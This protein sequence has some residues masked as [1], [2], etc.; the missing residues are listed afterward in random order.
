MSGSENRSLSKFAADEKK[1]LL[2]SRAHFNSCLF[3]QPA[4]ERSEIKKPSARSPEVSHSAPVP[5]RKS[6]P[7]C[8]H[9]WVFRERTQRRRCA[10]GI[11]S[12]TP[13]R[14]RMN[15]GDTWAGARLGVITHLHYKS[16]KAL[17]GNG[18]FYWLQSLLVTQRGEVIMRPGL[19]ALQ[20]KPTRW[21]TCRISFR[22]LQ[23][24]DGG[25]KA[26]E[27]KT[28]QPWLTAGNPPAVNAEA[29]RLSFLSVV[30]FNWGVMLVTH[31]VAEVRMR[32][33]RL[34]KTSFFTLN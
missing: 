5:G 15:P 2:S 3:S 13:R 24:A 27:S 14:T 25:A 19:S 23:R 6:L 12:R 4:A 8:L 18:L 22:R 11:Q 34:Q 33:Q 31:R 17:L 7:L 29:E 9:S 20:L 16:P 28:Q 21:F 1:K 32:A 10:H 26:S 30:I